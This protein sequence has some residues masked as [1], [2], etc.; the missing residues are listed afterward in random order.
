MR[1]ELTG[2]ASK[3]NKKLCS[4][5]CKYLN[6]N[7]NTR[8]SP[9]WHYNCALFGFL[10]WTDDPPRHKDCLKAEERFRK[11]MNKGK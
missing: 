8:M 1:L 3:E 9:K 2:L 7:T 6:S 11:T 5:R 4:D 10:S